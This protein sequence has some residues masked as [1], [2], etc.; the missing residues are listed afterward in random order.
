[1][2]SS[3]IPVPGAGR[4]ARRPA[5]LCRV[6]VCRAVLCRAVLCRAER[7][8]GRTVHGSAGAGAGQN[9]R[10]VVFARLAVW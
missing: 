1:M 2:R 6:A 7:R 3:R 4:G 10:P 5:V 8:A 9:G